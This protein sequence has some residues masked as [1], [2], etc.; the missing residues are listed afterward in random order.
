MGTV[1]PFP[2]RSGARLLT[3]KPVVCRDCGALLWVVPEHDCRPLEPPA[4]AFSLKVWA[5]TGAWIAVV[6]GAVAWAW[7][8]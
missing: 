8:R 6:V 4:P 2:R 5:W 1:I 7:V 3:P